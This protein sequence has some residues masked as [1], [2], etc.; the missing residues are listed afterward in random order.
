MLSSISIKFNPHRERMF[1][2]IMTDE[3]YD[4][5][6]KTIRD[7]LIGLGFFVPDIS[8]LDDPL[9]YHANDTKI[10]KL[11]FCYSIDHH[12]SYSF[13]FIDDSCCV[14]VSVF[15]FFDEISLTRFSFSN[16]LRYIISNC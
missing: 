4:F 2:M 1:L 13:S 7:Y 11:V 9:S 14:E 15:G 3:K 12:I 5:L 16:D 10:I 6:V 8:L